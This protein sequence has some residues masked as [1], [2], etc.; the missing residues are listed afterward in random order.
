MQKQKLLMSCI[1]NLLKCI[2]PVYNKQLLLFQNQ[3]EDYNVN[4]FP[5]LLGERKDVSFNLDQVQCIKE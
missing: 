2:R 5:E 3:S 4:L 1:Y